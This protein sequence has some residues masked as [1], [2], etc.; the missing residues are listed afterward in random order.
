M[1]RLALLA[2]LG[3]LVSLAPQAQAAPAPKGLSCG[4]AA[5]WTSATSPPYQFTAVVWG[6][7][8]AMPDSNPTIVYSGRL[9]CTI[10]QNANSRH[11]DPDL[12]NVPGANAVVATAGPTLCGWNGGQFDVYWLCTRL[13]VIGGGTL[14]KSG[15]SWTTNAAAD[16]DPAISVVCDSSTLP[17]GLKQSFLDPLLC[18]IFA[19][20][21]PPQGDIGIF[22]DC[23]P[24]TTGV[25]VT[26]L[27]AHVVI[28]EPVT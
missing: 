8:V 2:A 14:Y 17:C 23:P 10:Q 27:I 18:P 11:M 12:C 20:F 5:A 26:E 19:I 16:C 15:G 25:P 1:R 21:F 22:W 9:T 3:L 28:P 13:D 4:M 24:Y 6:G 7:P